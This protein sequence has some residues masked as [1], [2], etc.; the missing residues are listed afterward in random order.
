MR[1]ENDWEGPFLIDFACSF[2][3]PPQGARHQQ[4]QQHGGIPSR[5]EEMSPEQIAALRRQYELDM[6]E[7][8]R[9]KMENAL[10]GMMGENA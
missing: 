7:L 10:A 6:A 3:P 1:G 4:Q 5:V 9:R 2:F 8:K